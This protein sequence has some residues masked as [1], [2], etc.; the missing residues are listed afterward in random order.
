MNKKL[1]MTYGTPP[2]FADSSLIKSSKIRQRAF[3]PVKCRKI[4]NKFANKFLNLLTD[5]IYFV[6]QVNKGTA[7]LSR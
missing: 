1:G 3:I 5:N 7:D 4:H 2:N 6:G